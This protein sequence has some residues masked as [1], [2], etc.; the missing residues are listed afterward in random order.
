M[1]GGN[2]SDESQEVA[3]G[4]FVTRGDPTQRFEP[5]NQLFDPITAIILSSQHAARHGASR[6]SGNNRNA[7]TTPDVPDRRIAVIALIRDPVMETVVGQQTR[8]FRRIV[9]LAGNHDPFHRTSLRFYGKVQK[10][11]L[12][13]QAPA[14]MPQGL[15]RA[16]FFRVPAACGRGRMTLESSIRHS[17]SGSCQVRRRRAQP[18]PFAPPVAKRRLADWRVETPEH[19]IPRPEPL[20]QIAPRGPRASDPPHRMDEPPIVPGCPPAVRRSAGQKILAL[21]PLLVGNFVSPRD[22]LPPW[23]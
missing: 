14:R 8:R 1:E 5:V 11:Q 21:F 16:P 17:K 4:F 19:R 20:R 23:S 22:S 9:G 10:V 15:P 12:G 3:G 2:E 7:A 18:H 13:A 6:P